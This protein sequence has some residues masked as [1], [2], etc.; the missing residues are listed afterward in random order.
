MFFFIREVHAELKRQRIHRCSAKESEDILDENLQDMI[1]PVAEEVYQKD[2]VERLQQLHDIEHSVKVKRAGRFLR[3]WKAQHAARIKLK[4]AMLDFPSANSMM[5]PSQQIDALIP[6]RQ[7]DCVEEEGFY[8]DQT[9]KLSVESAVVYLKRLEMEDKALT[10]HEIY[11]NLCR[12]KAWKPLDIGSIVGSLLLRR[13]ST[14]VK[15][16]FTACR[17]I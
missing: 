2:V 4:R 6:N 16:I 13:N 3:I 14:L 1:R 12:K 15:G 17:H 9:T 8:V 11:R 10:A 7:V 5:D